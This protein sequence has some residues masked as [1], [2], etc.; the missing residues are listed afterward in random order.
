MRLVAGV[1]ISILAAAGW[2][3][4]LDDRAEDGH[5]GSLAV[6]VTPKNVRFCSSTPD[7]PIFTMLVDLHVRFTNESARP[8]I[9][10]REIP[11]IVRGRVAD[12]VADGEEGRIRFQFRGSELYSDVD[13]P[14]FEAYPD[15]ERF[16]VLPP[17][18]TCE[19]TT[20]LGLFIRTSAAPAMEE[21]LTVGSRNAVQVDVPT[22]P[23]P[24]M[25]K[26]AIEDLEESWLEVG[27]L[28]VDPVTSGFFEVPVPEGIKPEVCEPEEG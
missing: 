8:V 1:A 10:A 7:A 13:T 12:D 20:E 9:V 16:C 27:N 5:H 15:P 11:G 17:G 24:W 26:G 25:A 23:Y 22:W 21:S 6:S 14:S 3:A 2:A 19:A 4:H 18:R 28:A